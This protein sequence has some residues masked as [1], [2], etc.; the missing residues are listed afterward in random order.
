MTESKPEKRSAQRVKLEL[1]IPVQVEADG[2]SKEAVTRD[3]S[4]QGI[5]IY[6]D[7]QVRQGAA[8]EALLPIPSAPN[9]E[10]DL[11]VRC[12]CR[13]IRVEEIPDAGEFGVAA[14]IE[15]FQAIPQAVTGEP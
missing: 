15:E 10:P 9:Q 3:I 12:K 14:T 11:W 7:S 4:P 8:L 1:K 6:M 5:F 2:K 13:V